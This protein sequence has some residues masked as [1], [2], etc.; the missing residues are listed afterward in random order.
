MTEI[1]QK[2]M[3]P[4]VIIPT[5]NESENIIELI[6][7][8]LRLPIRVMIIIVDDNSPDGTG[9]LVDDFIRS[10]QGT[11]V[12]IVHRQAK[13]GLGTAHIAGIKQAFSN[14]C[15]PIITMDADFSH[16]PRYITDLL[17]K[18][19]RFD[20]VIGSRYVD[21]GGTLNF[22]VVRK[23]ISGVANLLTH[24]VLGLN[25]KDCT[26]GFRAYRRVC[27]EYIN[28]DRVF[29]D[30]YSFLIELLFTCEA[31]GFHIGE[32]P[33]IYEDRKKGKTKISRKEI[34][35]AFYTIMRLGWRRTRTYLRGVTNGSNA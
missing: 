16:H 21:G 32:V 8:I 10:H 2:E 9:K 29:S 26:S 27:L 18:L 13:L 1:K 35:K 15:D 24:M 6:E 12:Q 31:G 11:S 17:L 25:P 20:I 19:S 28:F 5:Y 3:Q 4:A 30:G 7:E 14:G 22:G 23:I 34:Y 33:I